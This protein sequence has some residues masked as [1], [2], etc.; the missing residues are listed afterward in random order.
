MLT[1]PL[2]RIALTDAREALADLVNAVSYG[3]ARII[4][5]RH[6]KDVAA[7]VSLED[8]ERLGVRIKRDI[9]HWSDASLPHKRLSP[10]R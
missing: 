3:G 10:K 5:Q 9:P 7:L 4:L 1:L 6:G 2:A 8:L